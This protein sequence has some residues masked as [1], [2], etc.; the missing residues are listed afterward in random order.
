MDINSQLPNVLIVDDEIGPR[1]SLRM[2]L[3]PNY[4]VSC[5][6]DGDAALRILKQSEMDVITLDLKMPGMSGI[7]TLKQIRLIDSD[8]MIIVITGFGTLQ[9][10]VEAIRHGVYD[11]IAKPFN[12]KEISGIIEKAV[13][14]RRKHLEAKD[15]MRQSFAPSL[16]ARIRG[17]SDPL[18]LHQGKEILHYHFKDLGVSDHQTCLE[19]AKVLAS[20]LEEKDPYT[21][22]HSERV[23]YYSDLISKKISLPSKE[24]NELQIAAYLHDI[25][26][27]GISN[28]FISKKGVLTAADWAIIKQHTRKSIE[29]LSPLNLSSSILSYIEHHHEHFDGA[30]YPDGLKGNEI[31]LG[32]R[33]IAVSD[34][35]DSMISDR[36]YRKPLSKEEAKKELLKWTG[37]Q[38]DPNLVSAFLYLLKEMEEGMEEKGKFRV[39]ALAY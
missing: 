1:E 27:I 24:R 28:R 29:L 12:V 18:S 23:C 2:I 39:S 3:K 33:I 17:E 32:A 9:S 4:N 13:Q 38:F 22:K 36:P 15:F 25:G 10:A 14:Q 6:E 30:G 8:V 34:S 19:F 31:P 37:K 11:Y 20:T 21:S 16:S 7:E 26:K 35:Y 5:A